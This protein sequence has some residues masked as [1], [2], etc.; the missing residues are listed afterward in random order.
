MR[1]RASG[2]TSRCSFTL[3]SRSVFASFMS[4]I[5]HPS[6]NGS[7]FQQGVEYQPLIE[8]GG[9]TDAAVGAAFDRQ[10]DAGVSPLLAKMTTDRRDPWS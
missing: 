5:P 7:L 4:K 8:A 3:K 6:E 9:Q 10:T 1:G 2:E